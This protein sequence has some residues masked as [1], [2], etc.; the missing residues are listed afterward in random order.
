MISHEAW[1]RMSEISRAVT[2]SRISQSANSTKKLNRQM[3]GRTPRL[4]SRREM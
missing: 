1:R 4:A 2:P 3:T